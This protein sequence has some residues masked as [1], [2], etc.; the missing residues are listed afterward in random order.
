MPTTPNLNAVRDILRRR[1]PACGY[2]AV[3]FGS[4]ARGAARPVSDWDIGII[5]PGPLRGAVIEEIRGDIEELPTLHSFDVVDLT[6]VPE[7]FRTQALAEGVP[8]T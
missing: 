2:R 1:L 7:Q 4:R 6:T 8:L 5:G 3:L